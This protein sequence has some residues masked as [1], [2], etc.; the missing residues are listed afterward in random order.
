MFWTFSS[1]KNTFIIEARYTCE[2]NAILSKLNTK[3]TFICA[4]N[5]TEEPT[6][7]FS[8]EQR[9]TIPTTI[10]YLDGTFKNVR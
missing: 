10:F 3:N 2:A 6:L 9:T 8:E 7:T 1:D 4:I 5:C